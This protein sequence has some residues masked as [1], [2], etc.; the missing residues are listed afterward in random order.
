MALGPTGALRGGLRPPP[1]VSLL[2]SA[3]VVPVA[4][5]TETGEPQRWQGSFEFLPEPCPAGGVIDPCDADEE[6][7]PPPPTAIVS[8]QPFGIWEGTSCS[9]F[10]K[11]EV[12]ELPAKARRL[13]DNTQSAKIAHEAWEGTKSQ[14]AGW[15]NQFFR[16]GAIVL[17]SELDPVD[18]LGCL[19][20]ALAECL[21][22]SPGMIH[23]TRQVATIWK[24]AQLIVRDGARLFTI[25]GTVVVPDAGYTG[26]AP[27]YV[28]ANGGE[29]SP[30][31][32]DA[33]GESWA[34]ATGIVDV[35]LQ[36]E[37]MMIPDTDQ[38]GWISEATHRHPG[39][40]SQNTVVVLA[41]KLASVA[42]EECCHFAVGCAVTPCENI[43][44]G[45]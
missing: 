10:S 11:D 12:N 3:R 1:L 31:V 14:A 44:F 21:D 6:K 5:D 4:S 26:S 24:G 8:N 25:F 37:P 9:T 32:T 43:E 19:E 35:R 40:P 41:E 17:G 22:G 16:N 36:D 18:A 23:V 38:E 20:Q 33:V 45:S 30:P 28:D 13:L 39:D 42:W 34:Y 29:I 2:T 7:V 15:G 27:I